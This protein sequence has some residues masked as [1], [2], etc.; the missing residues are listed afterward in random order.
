MVT[1]DAVPVRGVLDAQDPRREEERHNPAEQEQHQ[2]HGLPPPRRGWG[3][4]PV[5]DLVQSLWCQ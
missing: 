3:E 1:C 5:R 2:E 4:V